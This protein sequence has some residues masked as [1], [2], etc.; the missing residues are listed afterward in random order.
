MNATLRHATRFAPSD[1][2][3]HHELGALLLTLNRRTEAIEELTM[4]L[5]L[6]PTREDTKRYLGLARAGVGGPLTR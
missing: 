5:D 6:D 4:A 1:A 3:A 2:A